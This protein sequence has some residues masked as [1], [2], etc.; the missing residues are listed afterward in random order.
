MY[1]IFLISSSAEG[2]LGC[3]HILAVVKNAT[4]NGQV[5]VSFLCLVFISFGNITRG[6]T[7]GSYVRSIFKFL[8]NLHTLYHSGCSNLLSYQQCTKLFFAPHPQQHLLSS[9]DDSHS[10]RHEAIY[11]DFD[12]HSPDD[13]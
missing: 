5:Q 3:F 13:E 7:A 12:L 10:S 6:G 8:R 11:Y 2:N 4:V 1:D 9:L